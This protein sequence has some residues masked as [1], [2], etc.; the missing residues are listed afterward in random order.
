MLLRR[1]T[2]Q[3]REQNWV[4]VA[5][6]FVIVVVGILIAFKITEWDT[7]RANREREQQALELLLLESYES[8]RYLNRIIAEVDESI[9]AQEAAIRALVDG[10][11]PVAMTHEEFVAGVTVTRRFLSPN[12][13]RSVYDSLVATGDLGLIKDTSVVLQLAK[14]YADLQASKEYAVTLATSTNMNKGDYHPAIISIYDPAAPRKRRQDADFEVLAN[15]PQFIE[16][17]VDVL[18][19]VTAVQRSRRG[20]RREAKAAFNVLC[21]AVPA[22]CSSMNDAI[23]M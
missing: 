22:A 13:P 9:E 5:I 8:L 14:Y 3:L 11:M 15:D 17:S 18:R 1:A 4:A 23:D 6:D 12:P 19:A 20:V 21:V 7:Q 10:T 2:S 16:D